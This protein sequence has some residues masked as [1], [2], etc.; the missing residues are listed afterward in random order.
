MNDIGSAMFREHLKEEADLT[1]L[2][3]VGEVDWFD[4]RTAEAMLNAGRVAARSALSKYSQPRHWYQRLGVGLRAMEK[5]P[6][7]AS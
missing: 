5:R 4:F 6:A 3:Q 7:Q 1:I 2:P